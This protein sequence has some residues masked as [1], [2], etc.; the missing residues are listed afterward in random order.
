MKKSS[1]D[2]ERVRKLKSIAILSCET[3]KKAGFAINS[4]KNKVDLLRNVKLE[5]KLLVL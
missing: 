5:N 1:K 2:L 3:A 4:E